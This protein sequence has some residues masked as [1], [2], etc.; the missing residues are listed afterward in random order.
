MSDVQR[1]GHDSD[2]AV[3]SEPAY[4]KGECNCGAC[5]EFRKLRAALSAARREVEALRGFAQAMF[6]ASDW[7]DGGDIDGFEFQ[8]LA[9][10]FGLLEPKEMTERCGEVCQCADMD[11]PPFTCYRKTP[12]LTGRVAEL[13]AQK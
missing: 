8:E 1:T 10:K 9:T 4:P 12:L 13:L 3:H 2:C 6:E 5:D 7:P 11:E